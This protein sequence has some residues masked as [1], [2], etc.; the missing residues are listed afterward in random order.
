M[1]TETNYTAQ[2]AELE[3]KIKFV[4]ELLEPLNRKRG[5]LVSD[6]WECKSRDFIAANGITL[7]DVEAVEGP[8]KP[9]FGEIKE[10]RKWLEENS[11]RPWCEFNGMIFSRADVISGKMTKTEA[12]YEHVPLQESVS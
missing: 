8:G 5:A 11:E 7:S 4:D 9:W 2:A 1:N 10:F 12:Y 3:E 6:F